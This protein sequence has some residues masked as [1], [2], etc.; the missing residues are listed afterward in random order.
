MPQSSVMSV[1][2]ILLKGFW[3]RR[4]FSDADSARLVICDIGPSS[5]RICA[6]A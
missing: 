1:T 6:I 2:V 5:C 4:C 3:S